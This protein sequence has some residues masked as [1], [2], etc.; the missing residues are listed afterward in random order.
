MKRAFFLIL[1]IVISIG[2]FWWSLRDVNQEDLW[3]GFRDANYLTLPVMLALLL[4]F[5]VLKTLRWQWLLAPVAPLTIR[6]LF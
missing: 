1:G 6:Q 5:Y 3:R 4:A 2:C